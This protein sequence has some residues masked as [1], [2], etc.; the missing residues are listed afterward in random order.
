MPVFDLTIPQKRPLDLMVKTFRASCLWCVALPATFNAPLLSQDHNDSPTGKLKPTAS[1][2]QCYREGSEAF[3]NGQWQAAKDALTQVVALAP[4]TLLASEA[5]FFSV[6]ASV[7]QGDKN[8]NQ[9][10]QNWRCQ[11]QATIFNATVSTTTDFTIQTEE[12]KAFETINPST[13]E[14]AQKQANQKTVQNAVARLE[15]WLA[16]SYREEAIELMREG[17][18]RWALRALQARPTVPEKPLNNETE[19]WALRNELE[20]QVHLQEWDGAENTLHVLEEAIST[21][22]AQ[23]EPP[24]W[25]P[26]VL[27]RRSEIAI[28]RGDWK[29]AEST[30]CDIRAHFP[31]CNERGYVDYVFARCLVFNA[32]F[33]EARQVFES[34]AHQKPTPPAELLAKVWWATAE[35]YVMQRRFHEAC[36][37]YENVLSLDVDSRWK[38]VAEKQLEAC[39]KAATFNAMSSGT[40]TSKPSSPPVQS[41]QRPTSSLR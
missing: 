19:L 40:P 25:I 8:W 26:Q 17:Q 1:V 10:L 32:K 37:G 35:S 38:Q 31:K 20:C 9:Q 4:E 24:A 13:P 18:W 22:L 27:L 34:I 15:K 29:L 23:P 39:R 41:T 5:A 7:R 36:V 33:D 16:E 12:P 28:V 2:A 21:Y 14:N 11:T 6:L 3:R 30:V